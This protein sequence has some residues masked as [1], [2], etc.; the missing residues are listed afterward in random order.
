M[1]QVIDL[2]LESIRER[3]QTYTFVRTALEERVK[4]LQD[5]REHR[6]HELRMN[7]TRGVPMQDIS[8]LA[9]RH[10]DRMK[11]RLPLRACEASVL[12]DIYDSEH[13]IVAVIKDMAH[14]LER[15]MFAVCFM[16]QVKINGSIRFHC[17]W[18]SLNSWDSWKDLIIQYAIRKH[19]ILQ[20]RTARRHLRALCVGISLEE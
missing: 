13:E 4:D 18:N 3:L 20:F 9:A 5:F 16:G 7:E 11:V 8:D 14:D 15:T 10:C 17:G 6:S 1:H 2:V 19:R 12:N